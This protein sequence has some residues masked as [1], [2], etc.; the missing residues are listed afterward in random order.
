MWQSFVCAMVSSV[1]LQLMNPFRTGKLV[2]YEV[3]FDRDWRNFELVPFIL[4]GVLG[5]SIETDF[6]SDKKGLYGAFFIKL[7]LSISSIRR[8]SWV[9][10]YPTLEVM[11]LA[12]VTAV[13]SFPN[14]FTRPV[15]KL[16]GLHTDL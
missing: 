7:N 8:D 3:E 16:S 6:L 12:L 14:V 4:L 11:M 10:R 13:I 2:L 1:S 5:V 15:F 9:S